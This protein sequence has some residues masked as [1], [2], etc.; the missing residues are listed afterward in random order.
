MENNFF[1]KKTRKLSDRN[2]R[3]HA[4]P[5]SSDIFQEALQSLWKKKFC[6]VVSRLAQLKI[7]TL[8]TWTKK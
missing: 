1:D 6:E 7:V 2:I 3:G 5:I 4:E 8:N